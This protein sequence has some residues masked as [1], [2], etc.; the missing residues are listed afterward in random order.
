MYL[1]GTLSQEKCKFN[2]KNSFLVYIVSKEY[3]V[4]SNV[5]PVEFALNKESIES[6]GVKLYFANAKKIG[7]NR[8]T[9]VSN[10]RLFAIEKTGDNFEEIKKQV[11]QV[12]K[13]EVDE[14]LDYRKDIGNM[15]EH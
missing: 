1:I 13:E 4:K 11:Y 8:Y 6:K 9:S 14:V 2:G 3:S 5:P 7:E 10:S 12:I 15:Y